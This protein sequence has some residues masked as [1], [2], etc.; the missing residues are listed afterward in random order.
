MIVLKFGGSS[1]TKHGF[2]I[3][4]HQLLKNQ[5]QS[6]E[7]QVVVLSAISNTTS[8]LIKFTETLDFK[9]IQQ[10]LKLVELI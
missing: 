6:S 8:L 3:I 7:K 1:I 4:C 10:V 9:L 5:S 2:D